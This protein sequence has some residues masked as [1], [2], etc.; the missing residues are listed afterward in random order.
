MLTIDTTDRRIVELLQ[1]DG[2]MPISRLAAELD[3]SRSA[4]SQR[5]RSLVN[6]G[7]MAIVVATDLMS[8]GV[9]VRTVMCRVD[10]AERKLTAQR[11]AVLPEVTYCILGAGCADI[12]LEIS[13]RDPEHLEEVLQGIA[14]VPG[15][16][17]TD[18][19]EFLSMIK[20]SYGWH[21]EAPED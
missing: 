20:Q 2:R 5:L 8:M 14:A 16:R 15:V 3:I 10:G 11:L 9:L 19:F 12:Q 21:V 6:D 1:R 18:S 17:I 7:V 13:C 4:A